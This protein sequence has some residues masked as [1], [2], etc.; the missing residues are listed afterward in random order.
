MS[1][2]NLLTYFNVENKKL[3]CLEEKKNAQIDPTQ[4]A[5]ILFE[6]HFKSQPKQTT[7][8]FLSCGLDDF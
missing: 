7:C 1:C 4:T 3:N 6:F 8:F 2:F 5:L